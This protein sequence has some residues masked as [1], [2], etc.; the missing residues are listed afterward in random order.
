MGEGGYRYVLLT[1]HS[2]LIGNLEVGSGDLKHCADHAFE[3]ADLHEQKHDQVAHARWLID[4]MKVDMEN[5]QK[6][7]PVKE[8]VIPTPKAPVMI[9]ALRPRP[10][11]SAKMPKPKPSA[12]VEK[13]YLEKSQKALA[14]LK[15]NLED[16]KGELS[17]VR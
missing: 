7:F 1:E 9:T 11:P 6:L 2:R 17:K 12:M 15:R 14:N 10:M 3:A 8:Q 16:L 5:L 13:A 4:D